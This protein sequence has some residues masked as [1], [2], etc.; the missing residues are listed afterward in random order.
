VHPNLAPILPYAFVEVADFAGAGDYDDYDGDGQMKLEA[1]PS[2][3]V[4]LLDNDDKL[5]I[6]PNDDDNLWHL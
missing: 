5:E 6:E 3:L 4:L 1:H 2:A